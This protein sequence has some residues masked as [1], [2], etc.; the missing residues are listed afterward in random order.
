MGKIRVKVLG[1]EEQ[2]EK[3]KKK[4]EKRQEAK[5]AKE[6]PVEIKAAASSET[7]EEKTTEATD[8]Q[9]KGKKEKFAKK[10]TKHSRSK[11]YQAAVESV[12]KNKTYT[13]DEALGILPQLKVAS[14]DETV[15][16][17]INTTE[18]GISGSVTLPHGTGKK[19]RV[20][21]ATDDVIKEI[22]AGKINFDILLAQPQMMPKLAKV[23]RILGPRGLM[24]NPK[25][26][27]ITQNTEE[28]IKKFEA[29][30]VHYKTEA[31]F[32]LLHLAVGKVSFGDKKLK[33]NIQAAMSTLPAAKIKK[34]VLKSTMSP[35][36]KV[37]L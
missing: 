11:R 22:E 28:T 30:Q 15:E 12:D 19:V 5:K 37:T 33:E 3:Q 24:P 25:N 32:P 18:S 13:L 10:E 6:E 34:V 7:V 27:T 17:H 14:F 31:K 4:A 1:D 2:E 21:V 8:K 36:I 9:K 20:A 29:G 16:L 26:G 23:A 35:A